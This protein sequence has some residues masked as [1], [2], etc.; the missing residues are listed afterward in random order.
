ME[1]I[2]GA[3]VVR[4]FHRGAFLRFAAMS[5]KDLLRNPLTGFSMIF[6]FAVIMVIYVSMWLSFTVMGPTPV[7]DATSAGPQVAQALSRAG[8]AIVDAGAEDRNAQI[9]VRDGRVLVVLDASN[10]PAWNPIW[11]GL[12]D[13]G[14]AAD[15]ITVVDTDGDV[16]VDPLRVN[17]GVATMLGI[18]S[19][20]FIGTTV[21][22][23]AMRERG[24]LRLFGTTP[25]RRS[26]FL[27][28]QLPARAAIAATLVAT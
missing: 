10:R 3:D 6:M 18:A 11:T 9:S 8:V 26:T 16:K 17:L 1:R 27:L 22:L 25:L 2:V 5:G 19:I 4:A 15:A 24:L 21:P 7:A 20:A 28:A 23:V 12:R 14:F 13:A